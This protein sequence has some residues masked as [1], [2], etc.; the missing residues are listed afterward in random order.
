MTIMQLCLVVHTLTTVFIYI[1]IIVE[2]YNNV[3]PFIFRLLINI[4]PIELCAELVA[5]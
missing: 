3:A 5:Q 1:Y 4:A 2:L